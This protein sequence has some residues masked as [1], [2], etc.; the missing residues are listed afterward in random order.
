MTD[1]DVRLCLYRQ[2]LVERYAAPSTVN[3]HLATLW[4]YAEWIGIP[5]AVKGVEEQSLARAGWIGKNRRRSYA[6]PRKSSM[7]RKHKPR[8]FRACVIEL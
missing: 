3:R 8:K 7:W 5:V 4:V 1:T 6:R 2:R